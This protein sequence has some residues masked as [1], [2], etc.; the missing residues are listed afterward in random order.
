M[1]GQRIDLEQLVQAPA[2][3]VWEVLTD[4]EHADQTLSGVERV[5]LITEGPY[6]VGTQ[7]R[8]TRR[9]F[10]KSQTEQMEVTV[11]EAPKRTI[12]ES[13]SGG[14]HYVVEFTLTPASADATRLAMG[15]SSVQGQLNPLKKVLWRLVGGLA[16][17]ASEKMMARDLEDIAARAEQG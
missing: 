10:G 3:K 4:I 12:I 11:A 6:R 17:K 7:W 5:E 14:V 8:E 9:V 16:A 13:D 1:T 15:F 2:E